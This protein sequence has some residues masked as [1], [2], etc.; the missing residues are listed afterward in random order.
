MAMGSDFDT[1][2]VF[3]IDW[4]KDPA[5]LTFEV[6]SENLGAISE[7]CPEASKP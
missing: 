6:R 1:Y 4:S 3:R 5:K 7:K 2:Y